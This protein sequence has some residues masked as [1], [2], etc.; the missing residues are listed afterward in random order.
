VPRLSDARLRQ[1]LPHLLEERLLGDPLDHHFAFR[2]ARAGGALPSTGAPG[3]GVAAIARGTLGRVLEVFAQA[4]RPASLACSA[5]QAVPLPEG[6]TVFARVDGRR[7]VIRTGADEGCAFDLDDELPG[8]FAL[9]CTRLSA[10]RVR[11]L[12]DAAPELARAAR[13]LGVVVEHDEREVDGDAMAGA[14]NLLQGSFAAR[15]AGP[16]SRAFESLRRSG[17][18]KAPAAWAAATLLLAVAGLNALWIEREAQLRQVRQG[19]REAFRDAIPE[20]PAIVDELGQA[21]RAA[22]ALRVRAGGHS[23]DDFLALDAQAQRLLAQAPA[24]LVASIEY[25]DHSYRIRFRPGAVDDAALRDA[26]H[27]QARRL[28]VLLVFDADGSALLSP[29][30]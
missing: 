25:A 20:E 2:R 10:T 6:A 17:A 18:W 11:V 27:A 8:G 24:T 9:A 16:F 26:L 7:G 14:T 28:G 21:R 1:A 19:M 15:G 22:S 5:M 4:Q 12:G 29:A 23:P 13:G 3:V 30:Q